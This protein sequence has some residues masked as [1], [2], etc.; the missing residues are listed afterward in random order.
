[1][2]SV[3]AAAAKARLAIVRRGEAAP[4]IDYRPTPVW[5]YPA[6]AVWTAVTTF[7]LAQP[8]GSDWAGTVSFAS[9]A[10][11]LVY[12]LWV[13]RRN[14]AVLGWG[15]Q[16]VGMPSEVK[17]VMWVGLA[18][19]VPGFAVVI[20]VTRLFGALAGTLVALIVTP[21]FLIWYDRKYADAAAIARSRLD[22]AL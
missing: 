13:R 11:C 17:R 3:D 5:I 12:V 8:S 10:L 20:V 19:M 22:G 2:D 21:A 15:W 18:W 1:M 16:T 6:A 14:G 9:T 4:W 7:A